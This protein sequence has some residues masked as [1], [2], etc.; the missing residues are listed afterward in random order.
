[1]YLFSIIV[2]KYHYIYND[3]TTMHDYMQQQKL[4]GQLMGIVHKYPIIKALSNKDINCAY[5]LTHG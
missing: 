3:S 5:D 4:A 2:T 1:M